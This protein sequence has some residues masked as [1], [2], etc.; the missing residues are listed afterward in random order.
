M[1][2]TRLI[3]STITKIGARVIAYLARI[4][5]RITSFIMNFWVRPF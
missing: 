4:Y 5:I 2:K 3:A 1:L